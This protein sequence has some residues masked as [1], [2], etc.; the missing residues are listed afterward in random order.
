M[1]VEVIT[2]KVDATKHRRW[3]K[4]LLYMQN[5]PSAVFT[6]RFDDHDKARVM[7][8]CLKRSIMYQ[9]TWFTL[10][11]IQRGCDLYFIKPDKAKKVVVVD[12]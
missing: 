1:T 8:L 6:M 10:T 7:M 3:M 4:L 5:S 12:G 9:P 11:I 2:I